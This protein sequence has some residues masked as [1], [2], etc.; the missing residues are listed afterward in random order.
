MITSHASIG[1]LVEGIAPD[2]LEAQREI[3]DAISQLPHP[4]L[5]TDRGIAALRAI[6]ADAPGT[7]ELTPTERSID[8]PGGPLRLRSFSPPAPR[9]VYCRLHSGG[10]A[11]GAPENDDVVND[12]IARATEAAVV[13]PAY[14]LVPDVTLLDQIDDAVAVA[15]W[16]AAN[17]LEQFGAEALLIGGVGAGAHLAAATLLAL[18]DAGDRAFGA[19]VGAHFDSGPY[20]LG[21]TPSAAG[22]TEHSLRLTRAW[23]D[24]LLELAL[25]GYTDEQRRVPTISPALADLTDFPPALVTVGELDPLRDDAILLAAHLRLAGQEADLDI[26]PEG[27]HAFTDMDWPLAAVAHQR[28]TA[29]I[30]ALLG[31]KPARRPSGLRRRVPDAP[32]RVTRPAP[33]GGRR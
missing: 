16:L 31:A 23:V 29:W 20:D 7:T 11:A 9:A 27:A 30:N 28:A 3:N 25:P 14:R 2:V 6:V 8:G 22:A 21:L 12:R 33:A 19:F 13:S 5:R 17:A 10:W 24:G 1:L 26:W 32:A 4:D 15:R 18:R